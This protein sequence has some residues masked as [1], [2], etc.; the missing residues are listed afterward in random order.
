MVMGY[1][2]ICDTSQCAFHSRL[3]SLGH[4]LCFLESYVSYCLSAW[5]GIICRRTVETQ[6]N[7]MMSLLAGHQYGTLRQS[8][9]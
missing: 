6:V 5:P 8:N 1:F 2:T 9:L 3:S 7:N 4:G